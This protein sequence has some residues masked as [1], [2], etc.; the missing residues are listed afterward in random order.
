MFKTEDKKNGITD[1]QIGM[2]VGTAMEFQNKLMK[3]MEEYENKGIKEI[4]I[5]VLRDM[6]SV[7]F[8]ENISPKGL[9]GMMIRKG[10]I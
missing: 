8:M 4:P 9:V 3:L 2:M 7:S 10:D 5:S 1:L 6:I